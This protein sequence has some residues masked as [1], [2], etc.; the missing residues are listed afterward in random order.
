MVRPLSSLLLPTYILVFLSPDRC[1]RHHSNISEVVLSE[2]VDVFGQVGLSVFHPPTMA[3]VSSTDFRI[4]YSSAP[5]TSSKGPDQ[6]RDTRLV[7]AWAMTDE[8]RKDRGPAARR[9][10]QFLMARS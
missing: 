1:R 7:S 3:A 6:A 9:C 4:S 8:A 5:T 2:A 10:N